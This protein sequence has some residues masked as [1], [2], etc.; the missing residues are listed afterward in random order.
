MPKAKG[1]AKQFADW[2]EKPAQDYDP[3]A[4][5]RIEDGESD[6]DLS[7]DEN[8]GTEH[9]VA[10]GRSKLRRKDAVSL[11]PKYSGTRVSRDALD[12]VSD[13]EEEESESDDFESAQEDFDD[14]DEADLERDQLE[15]EGEDAEI[16]S[17]DAL[18]ESDE[19]RFEGF[20][21]RGSSKPRQSVKGK[22]AKRPTAADFMDEEAE[23][24]EDQEGE[25]A[26][27]GESAEE[28]SEEEDDE[29]D[30]SD[31]EGFID[32]GD[33]SDLV[34]EEASE[35]DDEQGESESDDAD[36]SDAKEKKPAKKGK[37]GEIQS[38]MASGTQ[39]VASAFATSIQKD[40]AKG[41]AVQQQR[42]AFDATLNIRI[43]LQKA[44]VA[45]NS[46]STLDD[47]ESQS[48]PYEAAEAAAMKLLNTIGDYRM[49]MQ[50][51]AGQKRKRDLEADTSSED[52]WKSML[53][54]ERPAVARRKAVLENWSKK[55]KATQAINSGISKGSKFV[56][57]DEP[58]T[59][60]LENQLQDPERLVKRTRIPRSCAPVQVSQKVNEDAEIYDDADF[61]QLLLKELVDQRT[62]DT[63]G[64]GGQAATIR[65]A[66]VKEAKNKKHVDTK[67]SKGRKMRFNVHEK[68]QNFMAPEDR[69][70]WEQQAIDRFFGTLFGQK[71]VL[72]E[73]VEDEE[74]DEAIDAEEEGLRLF[75]N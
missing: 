60:L 35:D 34:D 19:E 39:S 61:Y 18:G 72:S 58:L 71:M 33:D 65:Y 59:M 63:S 52:I 7:V 20:T 68:M 30:G 11:G 43:R 54:L 14:P 53:D 67:A 16:D 42:K 3:E 29:D 24:S 55:V 74:M 10:V 49:G 1:R 32:D 21:F 4:E 22:K 9:Y 46:L 5:P 15:H 41:K 8:A 26:D 48:E 27:D 75:R 2:E 69:R 37:R 47:T 31:L 70:V 73:D 45:V 64:A 17:D 62:A 51:K 23:E 56:K 36:D 50:E 44:L 28:D 40:V 57:V 38:L 12:Q 6:S 66:A 13:G 25:S